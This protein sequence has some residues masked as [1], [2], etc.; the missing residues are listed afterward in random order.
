[1]IERD[2]RITINIPLGAEDGMVLRV[3]GQ[4]LPSPSVGGMP[5]DL[6]VIL[7]IASDE[8]FERR[9]IDLLQRVTVSVE[10]C[11]L[12]TQI[13]IPTLQEPYRLDIP[14]GTQP[15]TVLRLRHYGL[16]EFG[17]Q[18]RGDMYVRVQIHI[19]ERL[20]QEE[21]DQYEQLRAV[22]QGVAQPSAPPRSTSPKETGQKTAQSGL[23]HWL[24]TCWDRIDRAVR[25]W[26]R[27]V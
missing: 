4:G 17:R 21:R 6:F 16:P 10:D 9:G 12:G 1:M 27:R 19:P 14:A 23:K 11:V 7:R 15:E 18:H 2:E 3:S 25:Q 5:G 22:K 13:D 24:E 8:R 20:S 26:L